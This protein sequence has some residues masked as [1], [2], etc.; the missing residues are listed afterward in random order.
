VG[1]GYLSFE[2]L[3]QPGMGR[4]EQILWQVVTV[5]VAS[6]WAFVG[7]YGI[8]WALKKTIGLRVSEEEEEKG[9]DVS[10]HGEVAYGVVH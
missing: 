7:T 10:Q 3:T 9:L 6:A 1:V 8:L 2:A 4:G 5:G